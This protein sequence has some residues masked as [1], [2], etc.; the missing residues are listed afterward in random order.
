MH[1]FARLA[2][3]ALGLSMAIPASAQMRITEWMYSGDSGEFV[4]FTNL[5]GSAVD[6]TG[7][8]MDD[9]G[10]TP[11]AFDLSAFGVVQPGESVVVTEATEAA[12]RAAWSLGAGVK[13]IGELGVVTGNNL[14]RNDQIHLYDNAGLLADKLSYGDQTYTGSVRTQNASGQACVDDIGQDDVLAWVLSASGDDFGSF[15]ATTGEFG[16]P[17]TY[18]SNACN[19]CIADTNGD[20]MLS[21]ADFSAWVAAFNTMSAACDQN[22]DGSCTPADFSAWVAN[23]NAGCN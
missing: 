17:G 4:E 21:P 2:L 7:W 20:G 5:S 19:T 8:S 18:D 10:A 13:I 14:G 16:T 6:M 9:N 15:S 11:G 22:G 3:C 12:F 1:S 23:Y